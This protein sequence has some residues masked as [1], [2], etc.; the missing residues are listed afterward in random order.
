MSNKDNSPTKTL[1]I[2]EL[3]L[4]L[5]QPNSDTFMNPDQGGTKTV[6]IGKPGCFAPGTQV[7]MYNGDIKNIEDIKPG[8]KVM[9]DDSTPR[10][11]LELC[12]NTDEMYRIIPGKGDPIIVNKQH[13]LTLK[14]SSHKK[15]KIINITVENFLKKSKT[16]QKKYKWFRTGVVFESKDLE[17]HPYIIGA[18]LGSTEEHMFDYFTDY[19]TEKGYLITKKGV[20]VEHSVPYIIRSKDGYDGKNKLLEFL[21]DSNLINNNHI[22]DQYKINSRENRL[23]LLAGLIDTIGF[24]YIHD[25]VF[26]INQKSEKLANDIIFVSRSL[27]FSAYKKEY[28]K[29]CADSTDTYYRCFI[30]GNGL[31]HIP[32]KL[33]LQLTQEHG[34]KDNLVTGFSLE[35]VGDGEYF[36]FT[37][38]GNHRFLLQDFSVVH[39][40]GKSTLIASLLYAKKH[41]YPCGIVFSGTE[42]SNGFYKRMFP[43][44]F[45]FN[46]YD[47]DQ[48][49]SFIKRQKISKK[50]V[51]NPWAVCLLDDCTDNPTIFS[52]PLQQ[53]IYKNSRHWKMWYILSLQYCMDV[54]PVIRT[55]VDGT[56]ILR[57]PN[58]KNRRSL[59]EN[60]AGIIPDFTQFCDIMD[61]ITNDY[62]ALYIHNATKSNNLE[63]CLFWYKATPIPDGFKFG[64]PDFWGF[65]YDRYNHDYVEPFLP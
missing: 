9:G 12:H 40:T 37:L 46:K 33:H 61:Y 7:L 60:Y 41:I 17:F 6:I 35:S 54:K 24:Y 52:K 20:G 8:E 38:D 26:E 64:C 34:Q 1:Y 2:K 28:L 42:D 53:G 36:G 44:T 13:I 3:N 55:N 19:F 49:R 47:E 39:N 63:D 22:P 43:S 56:F 57:E 16:F 32:T 5:I 10:N 23:E 25:N 62:T 18:W 58:L 15:E 4:G 14:C 30:S 48:L 29:S 27:G 45:I 65:H 21:K 59:W 50:H 11:V 51:E 31:D